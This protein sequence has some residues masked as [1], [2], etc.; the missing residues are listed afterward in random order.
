MNPQ[1]PPYQPPQRPPQ[2]KLTREEWMRR[3]EYL[4][5]KKQQQLHRRLAILTFAALFVILTV[6]LISVAL[7][8]SGQETSLDANETTLPPQTDPENTGTPVQT[9]APQTTAPPTISDKITICIDPGH[10][11]DDPGATTEYLGDY[12]EKDITLSIGLKLRDLL[13]AR[14]YSVVMTHDTNDIPDDAPVG[15]Q[16]LFG[17]AKRTA[18]ANQ[19]DAVFYLSI[20]GDTFE[21]SS[22]QGSRV[23]FQSITGEDNTAITRLAQNFVDAL[24]LALPDAPKAPLLKEMPDD[25]AYYVLRNVTMPAVLVEIGFAS[26]PTDAANMLD[27]AWQQ[28]IAEALADGID[29]GFA[30]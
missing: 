3:Q 24:T 7:H 23:Y 18:Y 13:L 4:R 2:R 19:T 25:S 29:R 1:R 16:Y 20:H 9:T 27:D 10:G 15:E 8:R 6:V 22:V 21:D 11:Y 5:R 30:K 14:G 12:T 26:N 28:K 17:L